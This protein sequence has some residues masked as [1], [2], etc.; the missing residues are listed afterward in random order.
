MLVTGNDGFLCNK[1]HGFLNTIRWLVPVTIIAVNLAVIIIPVFCSNSEGLTEES[2]EAETETTT[3]T[4]ST[5]L[6]KEA[7]I[8]MLQTYQ[9]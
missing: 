9:M 7:V 6:E 5:L 3:F 8:G 2:L 4:E 1:Y